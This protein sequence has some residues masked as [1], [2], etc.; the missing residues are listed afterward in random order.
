[1]HERDFITEETR[2]EKDVIKFYNEYCADW[3]T[4][5]NP[6]D[7][8]DYFF[9]KRWQSFTN[10]L[11]STNFK[12]KDTVALELGIG[13]GVYIDRSSRIFKQI[14]AVDGSAGMLKLLNKRLQANNIYNVA[15]V[16]SN[17]LSMPFLKDESVD[18]IYFF[19]LI[20]HIIDVGQFIKEIN[21][22]LCHGGIVI[23]VTPNGRSPWYRLRKFIRKTRK[24]CSSDKYYTAKEIVNIFTKYGFS[25]DKMQYWGGVPAGI[26]NKFIFLT[27]CFFEKIAENTFLRRYL[28]GITFMFKKYK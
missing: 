17:V 23:G 7:S 18:V 4:R 27:L 20:E 19:G 26:R 25:L 10:I 13:T 2:S 12:F 16:E 1:M 5:F 8:T 24:H 14:I 11:N 28:G 22:I 15:V 3:D 9:E 21:R 6:C